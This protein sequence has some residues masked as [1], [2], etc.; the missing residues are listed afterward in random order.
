[1]TARVWH[2]HSIR[3]PSGRA[4]GRPMERSSGTAMSPEPFGASP[5]RRSSKHAEGK[6]GARIAEGLRLLSFFGLRSAAPRERIETLGGRSPRRKPNAKKP[7]RGAAGKPGATLSR[8]ALERQN[9]RGASSDRA[10]N[11]RAIV[12]DSGGEQS[13]EGGSASGASWLR[14]CASSAGNDK[15]AQGA[16]RRH[17][18]VRREKLRR[19]KP[20]ERHRP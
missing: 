16:E 10:A 11:P 17:G 6:R 19:G 8:N 3:E 2:R 13:P 15:R 1:M 14:P 7:E 9:P 4:H 18:S 5:G 20:H 12:T